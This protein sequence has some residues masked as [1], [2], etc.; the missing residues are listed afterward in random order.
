MA[1]GRP[2]AAGKLQAESRRQKMRMRLEN[3]IMRSPRVIEQAGAQKRAG[4]KSISQ[5]D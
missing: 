4:G 2:T 1:G 3:I 5:L